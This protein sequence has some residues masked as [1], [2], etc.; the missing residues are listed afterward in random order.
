MLSGAAGGGGGIVS[1]VPLLILLG[2]PPAQA[3][4]TARFG[5]FGISLGASSRFFREKITDRRTVIIFSIIGAICALIGSFG[6]LHFKD[7][8]ELLQRVMGLII[9]FVAVPSMYI[10]RLGIKSEAKSGWTKIVGFIFLSIATVLGAAFASGIGML[11]MVILLYFFGMTALVASATRR[12]MQLVI[13]TV[14]LAVYIPSGLV[15]FPLAITALVSSFVGGFAGAH[16][17]IR[18]G[19]KFVLNLFAVVSVLLALQLIFG[20]VSK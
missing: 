4:A 18:R 10:N 8:A 20:Q 5:G 14:S 11:Q 6:L 12:Y 1:G 7:Q 13:A 9:L 16:I 2:L 19:D 3:V 15:D 17:A